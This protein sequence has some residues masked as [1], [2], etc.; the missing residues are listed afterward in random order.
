MEEKSQ[1]NSNVFP[2]V[3]MMGYVGWLWAMGDQLTRLK[4]W[5]SEWVQPSRCRNGE[6]NSNLL[7]ERKLHGWV[8]TKDSSPEGRKEAANSKNG[9]Q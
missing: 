3:I 5:H 6:D 2:K 7:E 9:S 4:Y 1:D 8:K